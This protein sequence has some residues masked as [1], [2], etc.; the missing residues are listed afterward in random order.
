MRVQGLLLT[1]LSILAVVVG[2]STHDPSEQSVA[3]T[4]QAVQGG[5]T[6]ATHTYA[7][8]LCGGTKGSC[9]NFCSGTLITPNL[10]VTARHCV[11]QSPKLVNCTQNPTFGPQSRPTNT[12][13]VTTNTSASTG[14]G[15][16]PGWHNVKEI[17][18]PTGDA[19]CGQDIALLVLSDLVSS[20]EATPAIPGI[21]YDMG[22][23]RYTGRYVAIGYGITSP[24]PGGDSTGGTRRI[25]EENRVT[26]IPGDANIPCPA[27]LEHNEFIGDDGVCSGD[28][29]SGAFEQSSFDSGKP[30]SWG[31]ASRAGES[32]D[33]TQCLT[34]IYT[35]LDQF[36][37]LVV[38][39]ADKASNNWSLYSKPVPD[40]TVFV[41][42]PV[43]DAGSDAA[44][45][46]PPPKAE[47]GATCATADD[48]E[49]G[50]CVDAPDGS[51]DGVCSKDCVEGAAN[52]CPDG[53]RCTGA[54]CLEGAETAAAP[55]K[56]NTTK[57]SG[58]AVSTTGAAGGT[59]GLSLTLAALALVATRR[60]RR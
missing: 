5:T 35:R 12:I 48:C 19:L 6:D 29:G 59:G 28:S 56:T 50:V 15:S 23:A 2:C 57:E 21:Q 16:G 55:A 18:R 30:V 53:F 9:F 37:D 41:P 11:D 4:G 22:D 13:Y 25:L 58:C 32:Q 27:G 26:C 31:I 54:V 51:G 40:W 34:S 52:A 49:S 60:R 7:V 24:S 38:A 8:G 10:V 33:G 3:Q 43:K 45:P 17:L 46:P 44:P 36:R 47:L 42:K 14:A 39:A 1:S 20:S